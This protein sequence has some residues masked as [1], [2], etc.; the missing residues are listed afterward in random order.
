MI[1]QDAVKAVD[2]GIELTIVN[3][4]SPISIDEIPDNVLDYLGA[5]IDGTEVSKD[6]LKGLKLSSGD[7]TFSLAN[8]KE[9]VGITVP[10]GATIKIFLPLTTIKKGETH[11]IE[12][13]IKTNNPINIAAERTVV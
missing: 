1:P 5:K 10:V 12:V 6:V 9:M 3:V 4:I 2:G 7:K 11:N 13:T 8:V